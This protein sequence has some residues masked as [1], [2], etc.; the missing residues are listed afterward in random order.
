V[1]GQQ[2][3]FG[4]KTKNKKLFAECQGNTLGKLTSLLSLMA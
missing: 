3:K 1:C 2:K 4:G